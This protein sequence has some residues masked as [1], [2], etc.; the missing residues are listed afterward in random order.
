MILADYIRDPKMAFASEV[1]NANAS[2]A[3]EMANIINNAH[4]SMKECYNIV[5]NWYKADASYKRTFNKIEEL[6]NRLNLF[7]EFK[8]SKVAFLIEQFIKNNT[9][10][11]LAEIKTEIETTNNPFEIEVYETDYDWSQGELMYGWTDKANFHIGTIDTYYLFTDFDLDEDIKHCEEYL[12]EQYEDQAKFETDR[13]KMLAEY[14]E[15]LLK[16]NKDFF[17]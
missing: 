4:E 17:N 12:K 8:N 3:E 14:G 15:C 10:E 16:V 7:F 2:S 1:F 5:F 6:V 11:M 13:N 9:P